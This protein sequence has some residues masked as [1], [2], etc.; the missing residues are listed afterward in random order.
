MW[1]LLGCGFYSTFLTNVQNWI[2][3]L[4]WH[5]ALPFMWRLSH[6]FVHRLQLICWPSAASPLWPTAGKHTLHNI[7]SCLTDVYC[8]ECLWIQLPASLSNGRAQQRRW[9]SASG[10][11]ISTCSTMFSF[12]SYIYRLLPPLFFS[13]RHY[14]RGSG[15][16]ECSREKMGKRESWDILQGIVGTH[17]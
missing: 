16:R 15:K 11:S 3:P 8:K 14:P 5:C 7:V 4:C 9:P 1:I 2:D 17:W 10:L 6:S 13:P 12:F